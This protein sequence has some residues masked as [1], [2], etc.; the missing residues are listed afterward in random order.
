MCRI[1][2]ERTPISN[3]SLQRSTKCQSHDTC[4]QNVCPARRSD[5]SCSTLARRTRRAS[6]LA[7][8]VVESERKETTAKFSIVAHARKRAVR[9]G[10]LRRQGR[11]I[12]AA[13]APVVLESVLF[14]VSLLSLSQNVLLG[15]F[16]ASELVV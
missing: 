14:L 2:P 15:I 10:Q 12:V 9:L 1:F 8:K 7:G 16:Q 6:L 13:P 4:T 5:R 11:E 3:I